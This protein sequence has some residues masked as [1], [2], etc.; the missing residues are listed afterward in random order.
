MTLKKDV[1]YQLISNSN[2][3]FQN[4]RSGPRAPL[5]RDY[6]SNLIKIK[7]CIKRQADPPSPFG[8]WRDKSGKRSPPEADEHLPEAVLHRIVIKSDA[9]PACG[10][11]QPLGLRWGFENTS[12]GGHQF[13]NSRNRFASAPSISG[14]FFIQFKIRHPSVSPFGAEQL[15]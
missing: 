7:V 3:C 4:F 9:N 1:C 6:I 12:R 11:T 2:K 13:L 15:I 14:R 8:L 5:K 10:A